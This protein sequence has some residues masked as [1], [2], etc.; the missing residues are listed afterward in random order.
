MPRYQ[1]LCSKT[2]EKPRIDIPGQYR[3]TD[4]LGGQSS[5]VRGGER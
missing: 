1:S 5:A 2:S 3:D 4:V